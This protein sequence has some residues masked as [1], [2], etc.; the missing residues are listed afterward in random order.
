[1]KPAGVQIDLL[2]FSGG[3]LPAGGIFPMIQAA[4]HRQAFRGRRVGNEVDHRF[5]IAQRFAAPI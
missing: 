5:V 3:D 1:M 4:R 2:H